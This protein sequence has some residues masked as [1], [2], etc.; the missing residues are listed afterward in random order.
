MIHL[1]THRKLNLMLLILFLTEVKASKNDSN[2]STL[3]TFFQQNPTNAEIRYV[4]ESLIETGMKIKALNASTKVDDDFDD[5]AFDPRI[6]NKLANVRTELS[7]IRESIFDLKITN[8]HAIYKTSVNLLLTYYSSLDTQMIQIDNFGKNYNLNN[9]VD[10]VKKRRFQDAEKILAFLNKSTVFPLLVHEVYSNTSISF[11]LLLDFT[12]SLSK[13][14]HSVILI[15]SL[16]NE[17]DSFGQLDI[18]TMMDLIQITESEAMLEGIL[19]PCASCFHS[20]ALVSLRNKSV[21]TMVSQM[22]SHNFMSNKLTASYILQLYNLNATLSSQ[23]IN[24]VI[25]KIFGRIPNKEILD[26]IFFQCLFPQ[27][28]QA[29]VYLYKKLKRSNQLESTIL[30][31]AQYIKDMLSSRYDLAGKRLKELKSIWKKIPSYIKILYSG[32]SVCIKNVGVSEYLYPDSN[33]FSYE[34]NSRNIFTRV[35]GDNASQGVWNIKNLIGSD[36]FYFVNKYHRSEYMY[37]SEATVDKRKQQ[38][39]VFTCKLKGRVNSEKSTWNLEIFQG[40]LRIRNV[41]SRQLLCVTK[42]KYENDKRLVVGIN[43]KFY[44]FYKN[45]LWNVKICG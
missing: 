24:E 15:S 31:L 12:K 45:C 35:F 28:W 38:N 4:G 7:A 9:A 36:D 6:N 10:L 18:Y 14:S 3:N 13:I 5:N 17:I 1:E 29:F 30:N 26:N 8:Q 27:R 20:R 21:E 40:Q 22:L 37:L 41:F 16:W 43:E 39:Y 11:D 44:R 34:N 32:K 23:I 25:D 42:R 33:S 2:I 19:S